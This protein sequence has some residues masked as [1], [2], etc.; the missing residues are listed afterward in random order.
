[1]VYKQ[2]TACIVHL[3]RPQYD[4]CAEAEPADLL[5][6][7]KAQTVC[8]TRKMCGSGIRPNGT[9]HR[10]QLAK[11]PQTL[12]PQP[13]IKNAR[14]NTH[15]HV[16]TTLKLKCRKGRHAHVPNLVQ[17][18]L[19]SGKRPGFGD[20]RVGRLIVIYSNLHSLTL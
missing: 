12:T 13:R 16:Y 11:F 9:G 15:T 8:Y 19:P 14:G 20:G 18:G 4:C 17:A 2:S 3:R 10:P 6:V 5:S 7:G 1:M